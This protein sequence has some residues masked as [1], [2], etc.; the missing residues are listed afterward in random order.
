MNSE[1]E[2]N[3]PSPFDSA[4][5]LPRSGQAPTPSAA[6]VRLRVPLATPRWA[7]VILA[8]N[9][10]VFA[11]SWLI[12]GD[13]V[14][15]MGAK[16]NQAIV[17]G[18]FWRLVTPIFLHIGLLHIGF[19]SYALWIFGPRVEQPYGRGRFLLIYFLSGVS[20]SA[21]SFLLSPNPSVGASGAIFGLIGV[22]GAYLY[23]YRNQLVA[24]KSQLANI[25]SVVAY[26]LFFGFVVPG[27][28]NWAHLGGLLAGLA[29]GW[30]MAPRY[31][32]VQPDPLRPPQ[33][34]DTSTP[35][36]WLWGVV[37]VGIGIGLVIAGGMIR[38]GQ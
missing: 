29:L 19:N 34:V 20:A 1:D 3:V 10:L 37:L 11:V 4:E 36:Q 22:T 26:N 18:E 23:R 33:M 28:D 12:G 16:V 14:L 25:L 31:Q 7:Y 8:V 5:K 32:I 2:A 35:E 21:F 24:G 27:V 9:L 30:F 17:A 38:W 6:P 15:N 13:V